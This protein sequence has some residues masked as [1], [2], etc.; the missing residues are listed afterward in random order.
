MLEKNKIEKIVK[1]QLGYTLTIGAI[2]LL[3]G[4]NSSHG[5]GSS[6]GNGNSDGGGG[7]HIVHPAPGQPGGGVPPVVVNPVH[8]PIRD[9]NPVDYED[10]HILGERNGS[11]LAGRIKLSTIGRQGCSH[12]SVKEMEKALLQVTRNLQL[13]E[14][15]RASKDFSLGF[16]EGYLKSLKSEIKNARRECKQTTYL[17]GLFP[18]EL[19]GNLVCNTLEIDIEL[20]LGLQLDPIYANWAG[21]DAL[22]VQ[23][24][25]TAFSLTVE[26]CSQGLSE[27]QE[28]QLLIQSSCA[29]QIVL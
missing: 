8:P 14:N 2:L 29:N 26:S 23:S 21:G 13:P 24:C 4:I 25:Q 22:V 20:A 9:I 16:Y 18:G 19:Y 27:S 6:K 7:E 11:I 28:L 1:N 12:Q 17:D 15:S 10:G 5:F 3:M